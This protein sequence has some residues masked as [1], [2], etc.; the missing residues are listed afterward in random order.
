MINTIITFGLAFL[1]SVNVFSQS[2]IKPEIE[3][4]LSFPI[5][6]LMSSVHQYGLASSGALLFS[7]TDK[8]YVGPSAQYKFYQ[9]VPEENFAEA[10]EIGLFKLKLGYT[11]CQRNNF[12]LVALSSLGF[13]TFSNRLKV[14]IP[15]LVKDRVLIFDGQSFT[16]ECGLKAY[17]QD[18]YL[19]LSYQNLKST[20]H[21]NQEIIDDIEQEYNGF[22]VFDVVNK[23]LN[24]SDISFSIGYQW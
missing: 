15:D 21:F 11:V 14:N 19:K 2:L 6:N 24:M 5:G 4:G 16:W 22:Q 17:F 13:A 10:T 12:K 8:I 18:V 23:P 9:N 3:I 20:T 1:L 7:V